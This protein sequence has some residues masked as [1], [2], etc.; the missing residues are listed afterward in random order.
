MFEGRTTGQSV[1][2]GGCFGEEVEKIRGASLTFDLGSAMGVW[3]APY[4]W[5]YGVFIKTV[6]KPGVPEQ[7][8]L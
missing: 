4:K 8:C 5:D 2:P 3:K 6:R 1:N 7:I